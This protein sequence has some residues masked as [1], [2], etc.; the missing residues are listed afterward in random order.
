MKAVM[1]GAGNIGRGFIGQKLYKSGY[2]VVFVDIASEI[3][4][5]INRRKSY[6]VRIVSNDITYEETVENV[7]AVNGR[8]QYSV[9]SEISTADLMATAVGAN[10]LPK[11]APVIAEGIKK[12]FDNGAEP[13]NI[14]ICENLLNANNLLKQ[15]IKDYLP[16]RYHDY[17]E[18]KVGFVEASVGRMVPVMTKE[19]QEND[20]LR[21]WVEPYDELPVDGGAFKGHLPNLIKI[22]PF[23]PFEFYIERKLFVHNLGHAACAYLGALRGYEF[24]WQAVGDAIVLADARKAMSQSSAALSKVFKIPIEELEIH[25]EDLLARFAN[26]ALGDSVSRVGRDPLRKLSPNDRL[27][28]ALR[29]CKENSLPYDG[30]SRVIAGALKFFDPEDKSSV[31]MSRMIND[32]GAEG[33]LKSWCGLSEYDTKNI[34]KQTEY[35]KQMKD[36]IK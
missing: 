8:E 14:I 2:E 28:G 17:I 18:T 12:R 9:E 11:V 22:K 33:I 25:V 16:E 4:D 36:G 29:I 32:Q 13:L 23:S 34:L 6:P 21:V 20:I 10:I 1:Y 15:W 3:V 19:M 26:K 35:L 31:E 30:I 5:E 7:R 27:I 24:I